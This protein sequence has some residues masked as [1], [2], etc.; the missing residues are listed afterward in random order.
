VNAIYEAIGRQVVAFVRRRYRTQLRAAALVGVAALA[1]GAY[2]AAR[3]GGED[4]DS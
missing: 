4:E 3:P 1:L 2:L